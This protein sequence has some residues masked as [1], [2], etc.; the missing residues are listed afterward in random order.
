M[1][2]KFLTTLA[3]CCAVFTTVFAQ[4]SVYEVKTGNPLRKTILDVVR[5]PTAAEL[6]QPIEFIVNGIYAKG[7]W[8]FVYGQLQQPGGTALD[9]SKFADKGYAEQSKLELFDNNF[10]ALLL[11]KKGKWTIAERALG[12]TDVCWLEWTDR[13]DVPQEIFPSNMEGKE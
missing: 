8:A 2:F 5:K 12:C 3:F 1:T 4:N 11:K 6:G 7:N 13:K 9:H 10:Q